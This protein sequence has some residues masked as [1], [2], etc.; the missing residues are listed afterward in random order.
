MK[1]S[2]KIQEQAGALLLP[3]DF[4]LFIETNFWPSYG[5]AK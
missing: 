3:T 5:S 2:E 1:N 4:F